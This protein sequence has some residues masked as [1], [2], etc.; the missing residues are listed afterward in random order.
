MGGRMGR[1]LC[2]GWGL[3]LGRREGGRAK[4][5]QG[6]KIRNCN[7]G[8]LGLVV[9]LFF[10][11]SIFLVRSFVCSCFSFCLLF[12]VAAAAAAAAAAATA[13][14]AMPCSFVAILNA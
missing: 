8:C 7:R 10:P 6:K 9:L 13:A 1:C 3:I 2:L 14:A 4:E 5:R 12:A 11:F